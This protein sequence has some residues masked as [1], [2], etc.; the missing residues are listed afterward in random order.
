MV[1]ATAEAGELFE[2]ARK[3]DRAAGGVILEGQRDRLRRMI[4]ARL[5]RRLAPRVDASDVVQDVLAEAARALPVYLN[6]PPLPL[7]PWLIQFARQ[8]LAKLHRHH[9]AAARRSVSREERRPSGLDD[10]SGGGIARPGPANDTSPSGRMIRDEACERLRR[11]IARLSGSDQA[12]LAMRNVEGLPIARIAL[13]LGV[14][15][16]AVKVRHLRALRR[17][18]SIL[19]DPS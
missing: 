19:E 4:L 18:R 1:D 14:S 7:F 8:R 13:R 16:G 10:L 3:G 11:A 17:L 12:L 5:D 9:I 15:E 2:E 6:D